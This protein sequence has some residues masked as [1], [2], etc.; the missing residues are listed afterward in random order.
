MTNSGFISDEVPLYYQ[1]QG[2]LTNKILSGS[3]AAEQRIP[4]EAD[5]VQEYGVSRIT[6]RQALSKLEEQGLIRREAGRGTFVNDYRPF[7][8]TLQLE[9]SMED[10]FSLGLATSVKVVKV[11]KAPPSAQA[12]KMLDLP[13]GSQVI[14]CTRIRFH[15][16]EPY[17]QVVN[18]LPF[19]IGRKLTRA[20]WKGSVSRVL[21]EKLHIPLLQ[22]SQSIRASLADGELARALS[23]QIGAPLLSVQRL[24]LS[25]GNRPVDYVQT[26]YRSDIFCFTVHF[27]KEHS[28]SD[29]ILRKNE[30]RIE[31]RRDKH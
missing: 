4:T 28:Q 1:L 15:H 29:W 18:E 26:H 13:P 14:R 30:N 19:E 12:M 11:L 6:V 7:A 21:Q 31:P 27:S 8:G 2:I 5:L 9:G 23:T 25:D 10:L 17:C 20:D 24:V 16:N 22:A 3:F